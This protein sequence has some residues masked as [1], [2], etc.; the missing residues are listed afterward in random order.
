MFTACNFALIYFIYL[1]EHQFH[2]LHTLILPLYYM[3]YPV[4]FDFLSLSFFL[5]QFLHCSQTKKIL[6]ASM[7][8]EV[9]IWQGRGKKISVILRKNMT[10]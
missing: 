6:F 9:K 4:I 7:S 3:L 10:N 2:L 1:D 5:F 8:Q